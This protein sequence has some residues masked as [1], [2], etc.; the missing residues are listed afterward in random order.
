MNLI[1]N[2]QS[3]IENNNFDEA[4]DILVSELISNPKDFHI[5][6][7]AA[8]VHL[9]LDDLSQALIYISSAQKY[10]GN[11]DWFFYQVL[12]DIYS[13]RGEKNQAY[14]A[15]FHALVRNS[16]ND[17]LMRRI[18]LIYD[19]DPQNSMLEF[20][21]IKGMGAYIE[22]G[23]GKRLNIQ[24]ESSSAAM[25]KPYIAE[26]NNVHSVGQSSAIFSSDMIYLADDQDYAE[27]ERSDI[28]STT[29]TRNIIGFK[30]A[31]GKDEQD[32]V[33]AGIPNQSL[34]IES[35]IVLNSRAADNYYHWLLEVVPKWVLIATCAVYVSLPILVHG[36]MP[37]QHY[38]ILQNLLGENRQVI[39]AEAGNRYTIGTAVIP[40][41][42][43]KICFD[44]L[45][46]V[47]LNT[48]DA[49]Y[50]P[51][52]LAFLRNRFRKDSNKKPL[53]RKIYLSRRGST[54]QKRKMLNQ[55]EVELCFSNNGFE[56]ID[57]AKLSFFQQVELF[58]S[59]K[60]VAGPTGASFSNLVFC[61]SKCSVILIAQSEKNIGIYFRNLTQACGIQNFF[62]VQGHSVVN[63]SQDNIHTDY[64]VELDEIEL[65]ISKVDI[66]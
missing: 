27:T 1:K 11:E 48:D 34:Y 2:T 22:E 41:K 31:E 20:F 61:E 44:P 39:R 17:E 55:D 46:N 64:L 50:H 35:C 47:I 53:S 19:L 4:K 28:V 57:T 51:E 8:L 65:T 9:K 7:L 13:V 33:L 45:P 14:E 52:A 42:L 58:S 3:L 32:M 18:K 24:L 60:I 15:Y 37:D 66:G 21:P 10:G 43:S 62:E 12:G 56:I 26:L 23:N 36:H 6:T 54:L 38:V 30:K 5:L 25:E 29:W 16:Y 59:A 40:S 49:C 63:Q